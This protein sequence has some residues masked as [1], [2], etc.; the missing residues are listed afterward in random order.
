MPHDREEKSRFGRSQSAFAF[1]TEKGTKDQEADQDQQEEAQEKP[2]ED[3]APVD[4]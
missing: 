1:C 4:G 3:Q 2:Q